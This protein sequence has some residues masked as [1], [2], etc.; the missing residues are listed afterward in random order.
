V[1]HNKRIPE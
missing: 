1:E